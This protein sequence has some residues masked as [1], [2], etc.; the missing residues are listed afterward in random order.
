MLAKVYRSLGEP[1]KSDDIISP[2]SAAEPGR[3]KR[4]HKRGDKT[5]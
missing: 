1:E 2:P 4:M 5:S 3:Q